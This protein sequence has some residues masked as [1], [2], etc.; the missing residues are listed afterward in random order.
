MNGHLVVGAVGVR[1]NE[2]FIGADSLLE[3]VERPVSR[4]PVLSGALYHQRH[5][6]R[7]EQRYM[8]MYNHSA[9]KIY[10]RM[11]GTCTKYMLHCELLSKCCHVT[12]S[13]AWVLMMELQCNRVK[14]YITDKLSDCQHKSMITHRSKC[15]N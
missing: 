11:I 12:R 1:T 6:C 7:K 2:D 15:T 3:T 13:R 14:I 9:N 10:V 8:Y 5:A 4:R